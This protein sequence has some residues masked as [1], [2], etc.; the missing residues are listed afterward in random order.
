MKDL[1]PFVTNE[2]GFSIAE[3]IVGDEYDPET[4]RKE[5]LHIKKV[6]PGVAEFIKLWSRHG[7][8]KLKTAIMGICVYRLLESQAEADRMAA[9]YKLK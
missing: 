8:N 2:V 9:E 7:D 4:W 1:L 6:N 3:S 5:Y